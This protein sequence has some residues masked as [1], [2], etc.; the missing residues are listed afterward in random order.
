MGCPGLYALC[1]EVLY[2]MGIKLHAFGISITFAIFIRVFGSVIL[3]PLGKPGLNGS[4]S[5]ATLIDPNTISP[6]GVERECL[7]NILT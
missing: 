6:I 4:M 7:W 3:P 1:V 5:A 2:F